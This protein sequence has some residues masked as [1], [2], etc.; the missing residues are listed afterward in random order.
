MRYRIARV[1]ALGCLAIALTVL[2]LWD[3]MQLVLED[4]QAA[5]T[6]VERLVQYGLGLP[7]PGTP[8]TDRLDQ[9][10]GERG[11]ELGAQ[12]F[13]RIFKAE[14]ELEVWLRRGQQFE[15][16]ATYPICR[17]SGRLGPNTKPIT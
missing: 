12:I 11:H 1:L 9:R 13:I 6:K 16:F 15:K 7:L 14:S 3:R 8:A 2:A 10:L 5:R 17:W 4:Q